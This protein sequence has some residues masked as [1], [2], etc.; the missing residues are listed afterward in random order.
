ML[1]LYTASSK[2]I[3]SGSL[4]HVGSGTGVG[5][6]GYGVYFGAFDT[7]MAYYAKYSRHDDSMQAFFDGEEEMDMP[8]EPGT[9]AHQI[10]EMSK[11]LTFDEIQERVSSVPELSDALNV[12]FKDEEPLFR[13]EYGAMNLASIPELGW[14]GKEVTGPVEDWENPCNLDLDEVAGK[15]LNFRYGKSGMQDFASKL[16]S[17]GVN[18]DVDI[19][20]DASAVLQALFDNITDRLWDEDLFD[21]FDENDVEEVWRA[22]LRGDFYSDFEAEDFFDEHVKNTDE[23]ALMRDIVKQ[24][25]MPSLEPSEEL[26]NG[27]LYEHFSNTAGGPDAAKFF[28]RNLGIEGFYA[29]AMEGGEGRLE[30]VLF[31]DD[32]LKRTKFKRVSQHDF[33]VLENDSVLRPG[34]NGDDDDM[35]LQYQYRR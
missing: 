30:L 2:E 23:Y 34:S 28:S 6:Y 26:T 20:K 5:R 32:L 16:E 21:D 1:E 8:I 31:G 25:N 3:K 27:D 33:G 17:V 12:M 24:A 15:F 9:P 14:N 29:P 10:A 35:S 22:H 11:T 19:V 18:V 7:A 4:E 13:L